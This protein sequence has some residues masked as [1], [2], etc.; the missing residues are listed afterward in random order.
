MEQLARRIDSSRWTRAHGLIFTSTSLGMLIWGLEAT[1]GPAGYLVFHKSILFLVAYY[2]LDIMGDLVIARL[3]DMSLAR[4]GAFY[5]TMS[6]IGAG[7]LVLGFDIALTGGRGLGAVLVG[8]LGAALMK[9]GIEGDVPVSLAFLAENTPARHRTR[10]LVLGPNFANV[11][12]ALGSAIL[13]LTYSSTSSYLYAAYSLIAV[14]LAV[15]GVTFAVRVSMPESVR[16]LLEKGAAG[17]ASREAERLSAE[18]VHEVRE[19][20]PTVGLWGRYAFL[21]VLGVV[22]YL[23]YGLMAF[24]IAYFYY[25]GATIYLIMLV[26]NVAA[27][28]A[29]LPAAFLPDVMDSR[30]FSVLAYVGGLASIGLIAV[31]LAE[32]NQQAFLSA[33]YPL[34]FVNMFFSE[35]AW[36]VRTIYEPLLFPTNV[37]ATMIGLVRVA[38]ILSYDVSLY[39]TS[40]WTEWQFVAFNSALWGVGALAAVVWRLVGYDVR[41]ALLESVSSPRAGRAAV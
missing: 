25:S 23:T 7:L 39:V 40:S 8:L 11:G 9:V 3:S 13:L 6:M 10:V 22:Q 14:T 18:P 4:K 12:A 17:R 36:A 41:R 5:L 16:W 35:L 37:R 34:L 15:L 28:L 27:S 2:A 29:G 19:V 26:A 31:A 24:T 21:A 32:L 20:T 1:I 33:F 38:P 30:D